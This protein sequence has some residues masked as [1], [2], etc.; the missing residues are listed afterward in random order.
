MAEWCWS[1]V[2]EMLLKFEKR[3]SMSLSN[4]L[5]VFRLG[6]WGSG[7]MWRVAVDFGKSF[8]FLKRSTNGDLRTACLLLSLFLIRELSWMFIWRI[9]QRLSFPV[10]VSSSF[11]GCWC[12]WCDGGSFCLTS[13]MRNWQ[14]FQDSKRSLESLRLFNGVG[15]SGCLFIVFK[16]TLGFFFGSF[17]LLIK[18]KKRKYKKNTEII[19]NTKIWYSIFGIYQTHWLPP[20]KQTKTSF[21]LS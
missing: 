3:H 13:W 18:K 8:G 14:T 17:I 6:L 15:G 7:L 9:L 16:G 1:K 20:N 21:L 19:E 12:H 5:K 11:W 10:V 4:A 2:D